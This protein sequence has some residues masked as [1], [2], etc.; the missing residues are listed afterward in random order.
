MDDD[1][2]LQ[3]QLPAL[4]VPI[5]DQTVVQS[6]FFTFSL[7]ADTFFDPDEGDVITY[8]ATLANG[9]PL[10]SWLSFNSSNLTFSG[11]A[12]F[13]AEG[14]LD[15]RVNATDTSGETA[16]DVFRLIVDDGPDVPV[17]L[18]P[19]PAQQ[20]SQGEAFSFIIPG[21]TFADP[22]EGDIL[23]Y[24]AVLIPG[25]PLPAWLIFDPASQTFTGT[26]GNDDVGREQIVIT[27]TDTTG[28]TAS[29]S[30][31]LTVLN[32]NDAPILVTPIIDQVAT[33]NAAFAYQISDTTFT[34]IDVGDS[35]T[36]SAQLEGG[37]PLPSW[38]SFDATTRTLS[39]TPNN[40]NVG[41]IAIQITATDTSGAVTSDTFI[42]TVQDVAY[43]PFA[44]NPIPD[45]NA[46]QGQ[47]FAFTFAENTFSDIDIGEIFTYSASLATG[48]PLPSWLIFDPI[49]RTFSGTPSN[50]NIGVL[51]IVVVVTD[52]TGLQASVNFNLT[53]A[54]INDAPTLANPLPDQLWSVNYPLAY[55]IPVTA[56][57]DID[58]LVTPNE[59]LT[60]TATLADGSALPS[61]LSFDPVT[62]TFSGAPTADQLG[63][64]YS[65]LVTVTDAA[66]ATAQDTFQL[67]IT[68]TF[69]P[70]QYGASNLDIADASGYNLDALTNHFFNIG[71]FE[72]RQV[73]TFDEFLYQASNPDLLAEFG[74]NPALATQQYI[75]SGRFEDR[76][77][78][79]F[80]SQQY[81]ASYT[82]LLSVLGNNPNA[83]LLHYLQAGYNEGRVPDQFDELNYI[84]SYG[85]LVEAFKTD[86]QKAISH[87]LASG[88]LE[89]RDP[90]LFKPDQY[91]AS[92]KEDL[93]PAFGYDLSAATNHYIVFG[94]GENRVTDSFNEL[95]YLASN[96]D[97][98]T[99]FGL[100]PTAATKHY[101]DF[102]L[103][104]P[105]PIDT[106]S[107]AQY[108]AS[109]TDLLT[110]FGNDPNA[111]TVQYIAS[112]F[113]QE[114]SADNFD[115]LRYLA[116]YN[117]LIDQFGADGAAATQHYLDSGFAQ[118]RNPLLFQPDQYIAS[119]KDLIQEFGSNLSA[120]TN[121][122]V[123][124]GYQ[125][126]RV[127]DSFNELLYLASN[128]VDL[129]PAYGLNTAA[130]TQH[131]IEFGS[132]EP[133]PTNTF[134][135][136]QYLASNTDVLQAFG[137]DPNAAL[138]HYIQMGYNEGRSPDSF[139]ELGYIASYGDLTEEFGTDGA[140]ATLHYLNSGF[141]QNRNPNLFD[142]AEYIAG[143]DDLLNPSSGLGYNLNAGIQHY[144][145]EGYKEGRTDDQFSS[146]IYVA[147]YEDLITAFGYNL[148]A[149]SEHYITMGASEGRERAIF[150]PLSYLSN[151]S[152][153]QA[154]Y[155][156]D[157]VGATRHY[158][159]SGFA[160]GR[161]F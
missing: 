100:N 51:P 124:M 59:A 133:R 158:I 120:A 160:E 43:P 26:P 3:N 119:Y 80:D 23:T 146:D 58:L 67:P 93:I 24:S 14:V 88:F 153:L 161:V 28:L 121:H 108:L 38:L 141:A 96:P 36:Y 154:V 115:E 155:G 132:S 90:L 42:L 77:L 41:A 55:T 46:T 94:N 82:D 10:P 117:S 48:E 136:A 37:A 127:A 65:I 95:L 138:V 56:F 143:Y 74:F 52:S 32:V 5:S 18:N 16:N 44:V 13:E 6:Q 101:I 61:W 19:I 70:A 116:S 113:N 21:T 98:I 135:P 57:S 45:Q 148:A 64:T 140:A 107:P 129:I 87:Y 103:S 76:A 134:N 85:D 69:D 17:V 53:T 11:A 4:N 40:A 142:P 102:I 150:D 81:L 89:N 15:I 118:N 125:E 137:N 29:N 109:N 8:S 149:G 54:N 128:P 9:D 114:R 122:Y 111:A 31:G 12:P 49:S 145:M 152:D 27:V 50:D 105:R 30:F 104:E 84:A 68:S 123:T 126:N 92:Y 2:S 60:Y 157:L 112:G 97:L 83:A 75:E 139:D 99:E 73:D 131:Y 110:F 33:E 22:D 156:L 7:A 130:A 47:S 91:I 63:L 72:L 71:R 34:D 78:N 35:I 159:E 1:L 106:F 151:Y 25:E 66:G 79:S 86:G 147:S 62:A 144:L 20:I 39:G